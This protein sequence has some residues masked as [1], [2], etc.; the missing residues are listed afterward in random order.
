MKKIFIPLAASI[1][2][3]LLIAVLLVPPTQAAQIACCDICNNYSNSRM[4]IP[5][6]WF[7]AVCALTGSGCGECIDTTTMLVEHCPF[8]CDCNRPSC[9]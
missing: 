7:G 9:N 6:G 3:I 1:I 8:S 4:Y 2:L 5:D